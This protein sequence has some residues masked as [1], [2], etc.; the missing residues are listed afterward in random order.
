L[1]D[2]DAAYGEVGGWR[3]GAPSAAAACTAAAVGAAVLEGGGALADK[4]VVAASG[5]D[6]VSCA[7]RACEGVV[8]AGAAVDEASAKLAGVRA[9]VAGEWQT[10]GRVRVVAAAAGR[11]SDSA[12]VCR[13][14]VG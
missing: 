5:K 10:L 2:E 11:S 7:S 8:T 13:G 12:P 1:E 9:E 4:D 6:D 3:G 14:V